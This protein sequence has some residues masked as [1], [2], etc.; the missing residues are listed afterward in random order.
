MTIRL[1]S[2][3]LSYSSCL[4]SALPCKTGYPGY[5]G[6]FFGNSGDFLKFSL[7]VAALTKIK[8]IFIVCRG[9]QKYEIVG[10]GVGGQRLEILIFMGVLCVGLG[11]RDRNW[12]C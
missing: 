1:S 10:R 7:H 11:L 6:K 2:D 9:T 4:P 12:G 3:P 5:P 8:N